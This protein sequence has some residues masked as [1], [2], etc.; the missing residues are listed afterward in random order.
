MARAH[1]STRMR[2][3]GAS[4]AEI[5][6]ALAIAM[7][8]ASAMASLF[9]QSVQSRAQIDR[10]GQKIE[11]G[12]YA[13]ESLADDL[14]LAGF[15]GDYMP[16][17]ATGAA[18]PAV[19]SSTATWTVP[20]PC[21]A[22]VA[23]LGWVNSGTVNVPVHVM[24]YEAHPAT[25]TDPA[26]ELP[27]A[28]TTCLP[29]YRSGTDVV[30]VRR[31]STV[32]YAPSNA[33][34]EVG[35]V[36]LQGSS[37]A[38]AADGGLG[39]IVAA[40]ASGGANFS[41]HQLNCTTNATIRKYQVR[42]FYVAAC[43][44]CSPSDSV[45]TLKVAELLYS[46]GSLQIVTRTLATGVENLHFEYGVDGDSDGAAET[47]SLSNDDPIGTAPGFSWQDVMAVKSYVVVRDLEATTGY[48]NSKEYVLG[49]RTIAAVNDAF[50]RNVFASTVR[51]VNPSGAREQP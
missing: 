20:Q 12:R 5:L 8:I 15:Y 34:A 23:S 27:S 9:A 35:E 41:L 32:S 37:C 42:I 10:D 3:S 21:S 6:V 36:F 38:G 33:A 17:S 28:L 18:W 22:T 24:G 39:F 44:V 29:N 19:D 11:S 2:Q 47:F 7:V 13:L 26:L 25:K 51:L 30:V 16:R 4:L 49:Q 46:G 40:K 43:D 45:P 48:T 31:A 1:L 50:R 14:R